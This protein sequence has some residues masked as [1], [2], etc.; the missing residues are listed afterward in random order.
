MAKG[1]SSL[2]LVLKGIQTAE[3]VALCHEYGVDGLVVSNHGGFTF[4]DARSTIETLPRSLQPR[5]RPRV[6]LDGDVRRGSDVLKALALGAWAVFIG[7]A[8][9][10]GLAVAGEKAIVDVLEILRAELELTI[11]L[12]GVTDVK[13]VDRNIAT[14]A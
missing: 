8:A 13:R 6:Y 12:S 1:V 3:D 7:R 4:P 5:A 10:W 11:A 9:L 2:P 14:L